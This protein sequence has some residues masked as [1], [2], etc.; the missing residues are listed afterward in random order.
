[1]RRTDAAAPLLLRRR[2]LR[3]HPR[4]RPH[5]ARPRPRP[6]RRARR[7]LDRRRQRRLPPLLPQRQRRLPPARLADEERRR[8][9]DRARRRARRCR[10]TSAAASP[11]ATPSRSSSAA[12]PTASEPWLTSELDLR[13]RAAY[14]RLSAGRRG[15][16]LLPRLPRGLRDA[17]PSGRFVGSAGVGPVKGKPSTGSPPYLPQVALPKARIA[18]SVD[19]ALVGRAAEQVGPGGRGHL[20]GHLVV[21]EEQRRRRT[22]CRRAP[23][24]PAGRFRAGPGSTG[25]PAGRARASGRSR[26]PAA[27]RCRRRRPAGRAVRRAAPEVGGLVL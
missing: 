26:F 23:S 17:R 11:P 15:G 5:L 7:R 2:L 14:E 12:S 25:S 24:V 10:S 3:P 27:F 21:R 6:R 16:R 9:P 19:R 20:V 13:P 18:S 4:S 22:S 1:M 8:P